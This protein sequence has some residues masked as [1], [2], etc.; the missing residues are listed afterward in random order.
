MTD[1]KIAQR[2][3]VIGV[4]QGV[5]FRPFVHRL[6]TSHGLVGHVGNDSSKVFIEVMGKRAD[7]D[8]FI[9]DLHEHAP[10]LAQVDEIFVAPTSLFLGS[11]AQTFRIV[12]SETINAVE[13]T[14]ISPDTAVCDDCIAELFDATNRRFSHPFITCT[15]C[16]PRL[17]II[18]NLPYD[19]HN[20]TMASFEMCGSCRAEYDDPGDRRFHAQPIGC[21]E[22]GPMLSFGERI[23]ELHDGVPDGAPLDLAVA[24]LEAG[25]V[26]AVKG[27]GGYHLMCDATDVEAVAELRRRKHRPDKPFAI[28]VADLDQALEH[29]DLD[30]A[31]IEALRSP[32]APIVLARRAPDSTL[33]PLV[34]P[35]SPLIGIVL[36][37]TAVHHMLLSELRRPVVVTSANPPGAPLAH[38]QPS[39]ASLLHLTD[40]VLDHDRDIRVPVDDSVVRL[41]GDT[42]VPLR[43]ARG[44]APIPVRLPGGTRKVLAV[45][46]ELKNTFC[47]VDGERAWVSQHIGDMENLE[48]L[49]AFESMVDEFCA[50]YQVKP[51][52]VAIDA[53]PGYLSSK[54]ARQN[55]GHDVL[56]EV[57]HHHAHVAAVM[58]EHELD[59]HQQVIGVA[60]DG[61]GY[62]LDGTI[63]GGEVLV[64]TA[65]GFDRVAHLWPV[66]LPGGDAAVRNPNRVALAQLWA[67][68]VAWTDDLAPLT[69]LTEGEQALLAHQLDRS[70]ACIPTTSMGRLFDAV[71]SLLDV[72]HRISYEAQAAIELEFLADAA[73]ASGVEIDAYRFDL[74][75]EQP[76]IMD[77]RPV[78]RSIIDDVRRGRPAEEIAA[79]F[80][81][82][83][84]DV[85]VAVVGRTAGPSG[86]RTSAI[87]TVV[88]SGGVFQNAVLLS[89]CLDRLSHDFDV[90]TH[91][92]VPAN[93]GGL[94]LGQAFV[95]AHQ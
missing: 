9:A 29:A 12:E 4:V 34:A 19:R 52:V 41:I 23:N 84:A 59:P 53:H 45:G 75:G 87:D 92:R 24:A 64:A 82:A 13:R 1:P 39:I 86:D 90:R 73:L 49:N 25:E 79:A 11:H 80:H 15:N 26:V 14:L 57:Q 70:I 72:R 22:C 32:Q 76:L 85:I 16:G 60:F 55:S 93:D 10:P 5:G 66:P 74:S 30:P 77:Q 95:A 18:A 51:E 2:I 6:A 38:T 62:G 44:Y 78:L 50:M 65:S 54:W 47:L 28:M 88:L 40:Q 7:V 20:T 69:L 46:G 35:A 67:A 81:L 61:T 89:L 83:V 43:R 63:W 27:I 3:E 31:E 94:S 17:S 42:I 8:A 58:A 36:P 68:G 21:H 91:R 56:F 71:A 33:P 48:T 37:Y